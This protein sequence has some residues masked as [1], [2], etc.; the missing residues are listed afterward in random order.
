[1]KSS[2]MAAVAL[3]VSFLALLCPARPAW[4]QA[5]LTDLSLEQLLDVDI[6]S[7]SHF[8]QKA[9][10]APSAVTVIGSKEIRQYGWR[11]LA[12]VLNSVRGFNTTYD[13]YFHHAGIR[14]F[15]P[16][17]D[18]NSRLL[19]LIDGNRVNDNVYDQASIGNEFLLDIDLVERIEIVRGPGSPV[20]GGNAFFG[21]INVITKH[22]KELG[23][24]EASVS[25]GSF[26][27]YTG[28][29]SF[30]KV[31]DNGMDVMLSYSGLHSGG[32]NL[33]FPEFNNPATNN[34]WS[35]GADR[36]KAN[37]VF[38]RLGMGGFQLETAWSRRLKSDPSGI[39]GT[40]FNNP[41][42]NISDEYGT[43]DA[44]YTD[45]VGRGL[46]LSGRTFYGSYNYAGNFIYDYPPVVA[47]QDATYSRW[48]GVE[49][50]LEATRWQGH[51]G[52]FGLDY[53]RDTRQDQVNF[54]ADAATHCYANASSAPCLDSHASGFRLGLFA[55]DDIALRDKLTFS[56][57]LRY[58][59]ST[60]AQDRVSPRL[61]LIYKPQPAS[62]LKLLYGSAFRAPNAY[63]LHYNF[64]GTPVQI[65]NPALKP[66]TIQTTEVVWEQ[67]P[68]NDTRLQA[69]AYYYRI[70]DW[71]V[72]VS[73]LAGELQFQNQPEVKGKGLEF[74][75]E[76]RFANG[77][78]LRA[79]LTGQFVP[80][81]PNGALNSAPRYLFKTNYS[82]PI[83]GSDAWRSGVEAQYVDRRATPSGQVGSYTLVNA[84]ILW[85]PHANGPG[86]ELSFS[87]Y[88]LFGK[89][90]Q[91]VFP[92]SSLASGVPR[93][94]LAQ[95]GRSWRLKYL[96]R[97]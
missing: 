57:G 18:Y 41:G 33:Y 68:G 74:E 51:H 53:Q 27:T 88:N 21:A 40:V 66:E 60:V 34:G 71:I 58:D 73:T 16:P 77:A 61:G 20:Y 90:Y 36:E 70:R 69:S 59:R 79:S 35:N 84:T 52:V 80:D 49:A 72:Q 92:D 2:T 6:V 93:E 97:F 31:L 89:Y 13:R 46:E 8:T 42:S 91:E 15:L 94:T 75:G 50:K 47:N 45:V 30:G 24:G 23:G 25:G 48:W 10:D 29:A 19:L 7:A 64:P 85:Q 96:Y 65:G 54:D 82:T 83:L 67:Y 14:G 78:Q 86:P 95:D 5:D 87:A 62:V 3:S 32:Q 43:V 63:E 81:H 55:Q 17:G 9:S 39:Y 76:Q 4:A 1:M 22:A 37:K 56:A 26:D 28:R 44:R 38:A 12:E 11:N